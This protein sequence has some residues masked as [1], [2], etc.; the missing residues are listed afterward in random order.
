M[1]ITQQKIE[2]QSLINDLKKLGEDQAEL[3]FWY[4]FFDALNDQ[5]RELLLANFRKEKADLE[6]LRNS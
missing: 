6:K 5:A 4:G 1:D 2:L 3:D